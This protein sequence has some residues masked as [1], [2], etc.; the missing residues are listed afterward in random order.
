MRDS[1]AL[2]LAVHLSNKLGQQNETIFMICFSG[3]SHGDIKP[4]NIF[5]REAQGANEPQSVRLLDFGLATRL[6]ARKYVSECRV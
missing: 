5:L 1:L 6:G 3:I 2:A 4:D